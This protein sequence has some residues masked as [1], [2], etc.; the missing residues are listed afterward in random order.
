MKG[1]AAA[2]PDLVVCDLKL[3][4]GSGED[5]FQMA[6]RGMGAPFL[7]MT[8]YADIDQAV[9]L[10]KA[11]AGDY[12]IKPFE[13]AHLLQRIRLLLAEHAA[14]AVPSSLRAARAMPSG[15]RSSACWSRR[16]AASARP[17]GGSASRAQPFGTG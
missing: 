17:R 5:V 14:P 2:M 16:A 7:F 11:G 1:L 12:V 6:R 10:M 8:A 15:F 9:R 3:P 13:M 4:D